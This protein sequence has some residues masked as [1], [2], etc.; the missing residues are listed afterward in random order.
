[1]SILKEEW[2]VSVNIEQLVRGLQAVIYSPNNDSPY[3]CDA[4]AFSRNNDQLMYK[5]LVDYCYYKI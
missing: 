1:M 2:S 3:N 4:A 5:S